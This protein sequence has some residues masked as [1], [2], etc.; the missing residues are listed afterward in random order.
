MSADARRTTWLFVG[1]AL[2]TA[3]VLF[4]GFAVL[5]DRDATA[6]PSPPLSPPVT[7]TPGSG[8]CAGTGT[9]GP[10]ASSA[11]TF[12]GDD[13]PAPW[14]AW[15]TAGDDPANG[16]AVLLPEPET[17]AGGTTG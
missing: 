11:P 10:E 5:G 12:P 16:P 17:C 4:T 14:P 2:L 6:P 15:A 7:C 8:A 3:G 13:C 1:L 9:G